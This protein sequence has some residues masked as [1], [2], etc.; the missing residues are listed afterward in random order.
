MDRTSKEV[1]REVY[2]VLSGLSEFI[3]NVQTTNLEKLD[4]SL[5]DYKRRL[6][7]IIADIAR[8]HGAAMNSNGK[9]DGNADPSGQTH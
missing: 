9:L 3:Q 8:D 7:A 4:A 6:D 1:L 5:W 2:D